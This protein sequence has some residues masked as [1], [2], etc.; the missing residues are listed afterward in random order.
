MSDFQTILA[1][2]Q[3]QLLTP[4][5]IN[6]QSYPNPLTTTP[7]QFQ[8]AQQ[9]ILAQPPQQETL[10]QPMQYAPP[11][12]PAVKPASATPAAVVNAPISIKPPVPMS[13]HGSDPDPVPEA[14]T[15]DTTPST[16]EV[17]PLAQTTER[18]PISQI[19]TSNQLITANNFES[20]AYESNFFQD[21]P[22]ESVMLFADGIFRVPS[23]VNRGVVT[24]TPAYVQ[25]T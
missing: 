17:A 5:P 2:Q 19:T 6:A 11:Q 16:Q 9:A 18:Y 7:S 25:S 15:Q 4:E 22:D 21:L 23:E 10:A 13:P 12:V 14:V 20:N 1:R 8:P 24:Y 3:A